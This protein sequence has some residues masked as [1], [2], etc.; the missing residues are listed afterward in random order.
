MDCFQKF[1]SNSTCAA[2]PWTVDTCCEA[3]RFGH[4]EVMKWAREQ[5]CPWD[6]RETCNDALEGGDEETFRWMR[7]EG[8]FDGFW[9]MD[10]YDDYDR[11]YAQEQ[12]S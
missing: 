11:V 12:M 8:L 4:L 9:Y 10:G 6:R 2:T 3:A 7:G 5:G 1:V